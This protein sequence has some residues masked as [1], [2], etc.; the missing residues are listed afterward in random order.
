MHKTRTLLAIAALL[1]FPLASC[2]DAEEPS[3]EGDAKVEPG[4]GIRV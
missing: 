3:N 1:A 4:G 2:G